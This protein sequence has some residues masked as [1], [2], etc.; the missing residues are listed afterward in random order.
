KALL[1]D[2]VQ[3]QNEQGNDLNKASNKK[4]KKKKKKTDLITWDEAANL[5]DT[6]FSQCLQ[7]DKRLGKG[8]EYQITSAT[9]LGLQTLFP[10]IASFSQLRDKKNKIGN[11]FGML[12]TALLPPVMALPYK[13]PSS[14]AELSTTSAAQTSDKPN[15][16]PPITK[17]KASTKKADK[18]PLTQPQ[19][20]TDIHSQIVPLIS[21][22]SIS[23]FKKGPPPLPPPP[24]GDIVISDSEPT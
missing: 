2:Q 10:S 7:V 5:I 1:K 21:S 17:P 9:Q 16:K 12:Q 4:Q 8:S 6:Y 14:Y 11:S 15:S 20:A 19:P 13:A 22:T 18:D 23:V 3:N 24:Q